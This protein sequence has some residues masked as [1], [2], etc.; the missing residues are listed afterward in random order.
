MTKTS[1]THKIGECTHGTRVVVGGRESRAHES[2]TH[3]KPSRTGPSMWFGF[4]RA[5]AVDGA[6]LSSVNR[7]LFVHLSF[8]FTL[9]YLFWLFIIYLLLIY[10]T[11]FYIFMSY[12]ESYDE[13]K[14][15]F[16]YFDLRKNFLQT[17][18]TPESSLSTRKKRPKAISVESS[19]E[20]LAIG[21]KG[22]G[23]LR[24]EKIK[25][26]CIIIIGVASSRRVMWEDFWVDI[27]AARLS[28][29]VHKPNQPTH[30][31]HTTHLIASS[32]AA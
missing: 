8:S 13:L 22:H 32:I 17:S 21:A 27:R 10:L 20:K 24:I 16:E 1:F 18:R 30:N 5:L 7:P 9:F 31:R 12:I 29:S 19:R 4:E 28:S 14:T 11:I 15:S 2:L 6:R 23:K 25:R 3:V 26:S